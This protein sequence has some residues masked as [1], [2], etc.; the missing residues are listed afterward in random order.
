VKFPEYNRNQI[1]RPGDG[2]P[3]AQYSVHT[4]SDF[5]YFRCKAAFGNLYLAQRPHHSLSFGRKGEMRS[6]LK[7]NNAMRFFSRLIWLLR[8]CGDT[9][10]LRAAAEIFNSSATGQKNF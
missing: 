9:Y 4:V 1:T 2:R 6:A 5:P 7:K 10:S 3:D 8:D